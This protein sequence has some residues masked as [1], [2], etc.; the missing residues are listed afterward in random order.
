M[1]PGM[2]QYAHNYQ[3]CNEI[4]Y[5]LVFLILALQVVVVPCAD[6]KLTLFLE[7]HRNILFMFLLPILPLP[8]F[9]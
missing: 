7:T 2:S 6:F 1:F 9:L 4:C 3:H 5:R 8:S